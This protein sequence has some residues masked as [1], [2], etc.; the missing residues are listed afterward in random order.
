[1]A[2]GNL[3]LFFGA[4]LG[5]AVIIDY[6]VKN[7]KGGFTATPTAA[8]ITPTAGSTTAPT[9]DIGSVTHADLLTVAPEWTSQEI[10][11]WSAVITRESNG[12]PKAMN[13]SSGA[14]GIAQFIDGFSEYAKYGGSAD[15]VVGQ[16]TSM[17]NYIKQRYGT[18]TAAL[19]HE[20]TYGWY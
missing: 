10:S 13:K 7:V 12:D 2:N 3:A 18:P 8:A 1:M 4:L 20:N 14:A 15:S 9:G 11:D 6:G 5:G 19:A 17:K 16:L